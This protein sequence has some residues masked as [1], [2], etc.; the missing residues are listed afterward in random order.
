M[1]RLL[2]DSQQIRNFLETRNL[3]TP[4]DPYNLFKYDEEGDPNSPYLDKRQVANTINTLVGIV[5]PFS[6]FDITNTVIG[7]IVGPTTPLAQIGVQMLAKQFAATVA[8]NAATDFLP[9]IKFS[10]LFDGDPDSKFIMLK[11]D[12]QITRRENQTNLGRILES[13]SGVKDYFNS[14]KPFDVNVDSAQYI[15]NSGKG[16]LQ[17]LIENINRN[18]YKTEDSSYNNAINETGLQIRL[19][20]KDFRNRLIYPFP[21]EKFYPFQQYYSSQG[22]I[23]MANED[24]NDIETRFLYGNKSNGVKE[25][26]NNEKYLNLAGKTFLRDNNNGAGDFNFISENFGLNDN[27]NEQLVWGRDGITPEYRSESLGMENPM[28]GITA[29]NPRFSWNNK[30]QD[31]NIRTG[32]LNYTRHLLNSKGKYA[33]F[34]MTRKKFLDTNNQ[35][36]FNGSPLDTHPSGELDLSRRHSHADPYDR[37]VKAIRFDGNKIYNG[38]PDSVIYDTVIPKFHPTRNGA[39]VDNRNMMFSIEN[40]A[41]QV[42]K[43]EDAGVA[44]I[45]DNDVSTSLPMCE[46]GGNGGR[47]MW[48]PPYDVKLS[49][50]AVARWDST[51]FIGRG[52]P[53]YTYANSE[54][55]ANMS[56]KMLADY[57]EQLINYRERG[58]NNFQKVVSEFFAFG[59]KGPSPQFDTNLSQKE[60]LLIIKIQKREA[61]EPTTIL[62]EPNLPQLRDQD[63]YFPNDYPKP[64]SESGNVQDFL[65]NMGYEDD[66]KT[67]KDLNKVDYG[68]NVPFISGFSDVSTVLF[69]LY[70]PNDDTLHNEEGKPYIDLLIGAGAT[71]LYNSSRTGIKQEVYNKALSI[72]RQT[73]TRDYIEKLFISTFGKSADELKVNII[74]PPSLAVGSSFAAP[75]NDTPETISEMDAKKERY[76]TIFFQRND[77]MMKKTINLVA[78]DI[79]NIKILDEEIA[80]LEDEIKNIKRRMAQYSPCVFETQTKDGGYEKGFSSVF[81]DKFYPIFHTQTPED[82]HRR[83]TFLHQCTRQGPAIRVTTEAGVSSKNSVFGRQPICVLRFGDFFHTKIVIDNISFNYDETTWDLNPEGRG[84]QPMIVDV[85]IQMKIIGGQ[86]LRTPIDAIQ[87]A[88]SFNY[89][90]NSTFTKEGLYSTPA[91]VEEAQ[92]KVNEGNVGLSKDDQEWLE[93]VRSRNSSIDSLNGLPQLKRKVP[94]SLIE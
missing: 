47:L 4:N 58:E 85:S 38:N 46:A 66:I 44:Y 80:A 30:I 79:N 70:N 23:S 49:E 52:E 10:N 76:A 27:S 75:D 42:I 36:H 72:R 61:I 3:Y 11:K 40:L 82:L 50:Q 31:F 12:F 57:P 65:F 29:P 68:L 37:Y 28:A 62:V 84:M 17:L 1:S 94:T 25:Y 87:N 14:G 54:R 24:F 64:G 33:S 90:A 73:A 53:I 88:V 92:I 45:K 35:L 9:A 21:D 16:Q 8:S 6:S 51:S 41:V 81:N 18:L 48:F 32:L 59:G 43:D 34:D 77:V 20:D 26:G 55:L 5:K 7:R 22:N 69:S 60:A 56:F 15:R 78:D 19:G 67:I 91:R 74:S 2:E 89:Y 13:I 86:S 39:F 71:V 93:L 63:L 83:L